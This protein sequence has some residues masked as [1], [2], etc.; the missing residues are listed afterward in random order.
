[1]AKSKKKKINKIAKQFLGIVLLSAV[2]CLSVYI[3]Y[4]LIN[5]IT[6]PTDNFIIQKDILTAEESTVG[7][8]IREEKIIETKTYENGIVKIKEE[9]QKVAKGENIF[10]YYTENEDEITTQLQNLDEQIQE[11][12]EGQ[13]GLF[14]SDIKS[15]EHQIEEKLD[16]LRGK[17]SIQE[18]N[19]YKKDISNYISKKA[20]IA[21]ELSPAGSYINDLIK[22]KATLEQELYNSTE[23]VV[24]DVSGVVSYRIDNLE[25]ELTPNSFENLTKKYLENLDLKTGQIIASNDNVVKIINNF[26]CYIAIISDSKES[27]EIEEGDNIYLRLSNMQ[28]IKAKI[29]H[30]K[31]EGGERILVLKITD[32]VERLINYRKISVDVIWWE[33]EGLKA[34]KSSIIYENG[35]SYIIRKSSGNLSKI[36]VKVIEENNNFC[37]IRNYKTTELEEMGYAAGEINK[38]DQVSIYDEI[39]TNPSPDE[40]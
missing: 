21:G 13:T 15:L 3:I 24:A 9:G 4:V 14:S 11:A 26:E 1:L 27:E 40:I 38:M 25:D 32:G 12:L 20:K 5:L 37:I 30:I 10:R 39:L 33:R 29:E 7:Y 35:L 28:K 8:V 18:I 36:L 23:Y 34:P 31:E 6:N 19:E 22:Q 2:I 16:E 17:N